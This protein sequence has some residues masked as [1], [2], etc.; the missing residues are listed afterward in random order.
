MQLDLPTYID[1]KFEEE[2]KEKLAKENLPTSTYRQAIKETLSQLM[3]KDEDVFLLGEGVDDPGGIFGSTLGLAEKFGKDRVIDT[4][5]SENTITGIAIGAAITGMRPIYIHMRMDFLYLCMDQ[6]ANHAAKWYYMTGGKVNVGL[7]IRAIIGRGWGAAAQHSQAL[8]GLFM[9]IP[10]LKVVMPST[11]YDVKGLLVSSVY[12]GNPVIFVEHRWLY[13]TVDYVPKDLYKIPFGKGIIRKEGKDVSLIA[14][15]YMCYE[16][17]RALPY[18][19]EQGIDVELIDLRTL[20]PLDSEIIINSVKKTGR[21][22]IADLGWRTAGFSA[23]VAAVVAENIFNYLKAPVVRLTSPET[24]TPSSPVLEE[25]FYKGKDD[26]ITAV[27]KVF[28]YK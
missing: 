22:V 5:I 7:V 6:I 16:A 18:L 1:K 19:T 27:K 3:E 23:E 10:G 11:A 17:M 26:I 8:H 12:D 21:V 15:S 4:P 24:P 13:D 25:E 20:K 9:H 2:K 28:N 14:T